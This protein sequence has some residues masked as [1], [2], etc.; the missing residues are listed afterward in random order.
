MP[1]KRKNDQGAQQGLLMVQPDV[2][3]PVKRTKGNYGHAIT[4]TVPQNQLNKVTT[5]AQAP[6]QHLYSPV[7]QTSM[8]GAVISGPLPFQRLVHLQQN[9]PPGHPVH[10]EHQIVCPQGNPSPATA[11]SSQQMSVPRAGGDP[12][13]MPSGELSV[14][15]QVLYYDTLIVLQY[16]M[17]TVQHVAVALYQS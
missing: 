3:P 6:V 2:S 4:Q 11:G 13:K 7:T 9:Q 1:I 5:A 8:Q 16:N 12:L 14:Q 10:G 17:L 15:W